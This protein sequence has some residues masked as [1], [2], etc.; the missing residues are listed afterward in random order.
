MTWGQLAVSALAPRTHLGKLQPAYFT[1][2]D[3]F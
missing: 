1:K 3:P 2:V